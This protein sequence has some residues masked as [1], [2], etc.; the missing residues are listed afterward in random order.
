MHNNGTRC[1]VLIFLICTY[2]LEPKFKD[3][4]WANMQKKRIRKCQGK[5]N[6]VAAIWRLRKRLLYFNDFMVTYS[7]N[8]LGTVFLI[9]GI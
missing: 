2:V 9:F 3:L 1:S 6:A 5:E 8:S 7:D 4:C